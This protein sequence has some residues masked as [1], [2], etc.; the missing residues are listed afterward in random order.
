MSDEHPVVQLVRRANAALVDGDWEKVAGM[1]LD[2]FHAED[3]RAGFRLTYTKDDN[4]AQSR[5]M[6]D[7]GIVRVGTD[8]VEARGQRCAIVR[9]TFEAESGF[10]VP[11][12]MVTEIDDEG[13]ILRGVVFDE[14]DLDE[15]RAELER[16]SG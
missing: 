11:V 12:L 4:L 1:M 8:F 14:D 6:A 5:V 16:F 2:S 15:A 7:L 13:H 9:V 10:L 3:R